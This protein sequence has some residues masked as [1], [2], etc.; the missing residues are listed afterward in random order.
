M[1]T[2]FL[3]DPYSY[4]CRTPNIRRNWAD[5]E[6]I[7]QKHNGHLMSPLSNDLLH[8]I[9]SAFDKVNGAFFIGLNDIE[10]ENVWK[11][12]DG[13]LFSDNLDWVS[14]KNFENLI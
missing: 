1:S 8:D 14:K 6:N 3:N 10:T 12:S 9:Y 5:A 11:L 4:F 2:W 13:E 7:C